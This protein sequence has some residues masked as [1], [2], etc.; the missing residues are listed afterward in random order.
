[1]VKEMT[2]KV[3]DLRAIVQKNRDEHC[4]IFEE[5]LD[6]YRKTA[7]SELETM[8][9]RAK[10]GKRVVEVRVHLPM[11]CDHTR[12]YDAVIKMLEL[13]ADATVLLDQQEFTQ[14][15]M[16]DW[17][18]MRDFLGASRVYGSEMAVESMQRRY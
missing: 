3:E 6:G 12:E 18:W 13:T 1:M 9:E 2:F 7:I 5:A 11:P 16:E 8:L 17:D 14:Y 10:K 4:K 15:V